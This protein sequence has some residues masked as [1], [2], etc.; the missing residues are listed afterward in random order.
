MA[1][2]TALV[3][4]PL[5]SA[6]DKVPL[7]AP[8]GTVITIFPASTS[9]ASNGSVELVATVIEKGTASTGTG[10]GASQTP[11]A[12]T[13]VHNGTVV[14]FT[15]NI[16]RIEPRE[17]RTHNG[18][19][20]VRFH[21]DGANGTAVITAYSGGASTKLEN[22][23]VGSASAERILVTATNQ[24]LPAN[25]GSTQVQ[26]RVETVA[27]NP[28]PGVPVNFTTSSGTVSP[29]TATTDENGIARATLTATANATVTATSGSKTG[30]VAITVAPRSGLNVSASDN[31]PNV[32]EP[33]TFTISTTSGQAVTNARIDYGDGNG[34][35]LGTVTG[36]RTDTYTY[37]RTGNFQ[38][39]VSADNGENAAT[40]VSVGGANAS[41]TAT[42]ESPLINQSTTLAVSGLSAGTQV[43]EYRWSFGDGTT[44]TTGG[45]STQKSWDRTGNFPVTVQIIGIDGSVIATPSRTVT[46]RP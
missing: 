5:V 28:V 39:T 13:P 45:P 33:V 35:N 30:T 16:G 36:T 41:I 26:A 10:T 21:A 23:L 6:C 38:V 1:V 11:A 34:R 29:T 32:G 42:P 37:T 7:L 4:L 43:R 44:S 25:G 20:R 9:V 46:V 12:G 8:T 19:V 15:T 27:G 22:L 31:T 40:S 2:L 18:E 17:A 3:A 14:S 24:T